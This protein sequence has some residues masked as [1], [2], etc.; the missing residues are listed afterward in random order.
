[1]SIV[2]DKADTDVLSTGVDYRT[3]FGVNSL[4]SDEA[5][6]PDA[7]TQTHWGLT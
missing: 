3:H 7:A 4:E 6:Q 1:M 5:A 2:S